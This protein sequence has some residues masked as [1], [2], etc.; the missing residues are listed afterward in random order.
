MKSKMLATIMI[1][2]AR[3]E[4][5]VAERP[6]GAA[7]LIRTPTKRQGVGMDPQRHAHGDDR[8][9]REHADRGR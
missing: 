5:V 9:Q 4:T 3:D 6:G 8:A 1:T 7:T 2:P